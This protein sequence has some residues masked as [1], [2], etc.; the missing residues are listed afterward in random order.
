MDEFVGSIVKFS[1]IQ[2]H[3]L[4]GSNRLRLSARSTDSVVA[5]N[6]VLGAQTLW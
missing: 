2:E 6:L 3:R 5:I 4:C 1:W